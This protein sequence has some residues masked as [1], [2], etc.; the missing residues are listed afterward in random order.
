MARALNRREAH[1]ARGGS[2]LRASATTAR[3]PGVDALR[4]IALAM[5]FVYHFAFDLRFYRVIAADF[6][7]DPFWLGFRALIV[8]SFMTLVGMAL[9][10]AANA[11]ATNAHFFRRVGM[12]AA[13]ALAASLGS[14]I[15]FP[16]TYIYFGILHSIAVAS[17]L[18]APFVRR[19]GI[20]LAIAAAL[21]V[22]GV[23]FTHP[24]FDSRTLSWIGF[25]TRKPATEDYVPL[26]P[27]AGF[28]FAGITL[29]HALAAAQWKPV[30]PF[31]RAPRALQWLGRHSLLVYMVH[32][33]IFLGVLWVVFGR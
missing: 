12:I 15:L 7:H 22:A 6:E 27:W 14:W 30:A 9:V 8:A 5:M 29:A 13:C 32:Q 24:A 18:A 1:A 11:G 2:L 33:P 20:A 17:L 3:I 19:P 23:T 16:Q 25:V 21:I 31:A 4:G 10:L 26:A 28:V